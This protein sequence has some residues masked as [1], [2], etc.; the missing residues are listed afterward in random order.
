MNFRPTHQTSLLDPGN[1]AALGDWRS[2]ND[3]VMG[4]VS[5]GTISYSPTGEAIFEGEV[6]TE[7]GGGFSSVRRSFNEP[8]DAS[9]YSG[10][11]LTVKGD[12]KLYRL[13]LRNDEGPSAVSF[14]GQFMAGSQ[15]YT[16][17]MIPFDSFRP[18]FRGRDLESR[19]RLDA[20]YLTSIGF[21]ISKEQ[22]S[23]F[24]LSIREMY[25]S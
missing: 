21:I 25:L 22:G 20:R 12:N 10:V 11:C 14:D 16:N 9:G 18:T 8:L 1:L 13:R 24:R 7:N 15:D 17:L 4:G 19:F 3:V 5:R 23:T 6:R 2:L